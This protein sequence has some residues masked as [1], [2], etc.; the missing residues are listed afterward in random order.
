MRKKNLTGVKAYTELIKFFS[1][2]KMPSRCQV[3]FDLALEDHVVPTSAMYLLLMQCYA[4]TGSLDGMAY[5]MRQAGTHLESRE[6]ASRF[7]RLAIKGLQRGRERSLMFA[8]AIK[9]W[10]IHEGHPTVYSALL[11]GCTSYEQSGGLVMEMLDR[12]IVLFPSDWG[13]FIDSASS[14]GDVASVMK[15]LQARRE[16]S[17]EA[18]AILAQTQVLATLLAVGDTGLFVKMAHYIFDNK[19]RPDGV[20]A[21]MYGRAC[22][23]D[24]HLKEEYCVE[25]ADLMRKTGSSQRAVETLIGIRSSRR[26]VNGALSEFNMRGEML[27]NMKIW[28]TLL[29]R[30][31][32]TLTHAMDISN[33]YPASYLSHLGD[34]IFTEFINEPKGVN[35]PPIH[36]IIRSSLANRGFGCLRIAR[37]LRKLSATRDTKRSKLSVIHL[38]NAAK[39][40]A[41]RVI[42]VWRNPAIPE[43]QRR[44]RCTSLL[45]GLEALYNDVH[46]ASPWCASALIEHMLA[47]YGA[48]G[49]VDKAVDMY[50]LQLLAG[51]PAHLMQVES[52][53]RQIFTLRNDTVA[54]EHMNTAR[55]QCDTLLPG[56]KQLI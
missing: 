14:C 45:E 49:L 40:I 42:Q 19:S 8:V 52:V 28:V 55:M 43:V 30:V 22:E 16:I 23:I 17:K 32:F 56:L 47:A 18:L 41:W 21:N 44:E 27:G 33:G 39:A 2:L 48:L 24:D 31:W 7:I 34:R 12:D 35:D 9:C 26:D 6:V 1:V 38:A 3:C 37:L 20:V 13:A 36:H 53:M 25:A 5:V 15:I 11:S 46:G 50:R 29:R 51:Y 10:A 4:D 54:L